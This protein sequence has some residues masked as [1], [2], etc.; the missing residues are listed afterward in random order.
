MGLDLFIIYIGISL[1]AVACVLSIMPDAK[2]KNYIYLLSAAGAAEIGF[3]G[4]RHA[5]G[6]GHAV[7]PNIRISSQYSLSFGLDPI[8]GAFVF[9]I[10]GL[11][12]AASIYSVGYTKDDR[13][14]SLPSFLYG[15]FILSMYAVIA[16]KNV[17]TFLISWETMAVVSYFLVVT[18][19]TE[20]SSR[21]GLVYGVLTHVGT[22][23]I[24]AAFLLI[25][26]STGSMDFGVMKSNIGM[27][28]P[29]VRSLVF[30]FAL[31]G[32]GTKMGAMPMHAWLPR[33]HPAA[34][35][36]V[37][38]LMSGVMIKTG[39]YGLIR[40]AFDIL[41]GG[42][43]WWG[44]LIVAMGAASAILGVLY[45]LTETD[46]KRLLA[47]SSIENM[48]I[49]MLAL[50]ASMMF[51]AAGM[52]AFAGL[53]LLAALYH[54]LNH[55]LF[56]GML[57]MA[58]GSVV[59][60]TGTKNIEKMGGLLKTMPYTGLFFLIGS[61]SICGLPMFNGFV[62]EWMTYQ[63][64]LIGFGLPNTSAKVMLPLSGAALALTGALAAFC[65]VRAFGIGF[66]G[67]ARS[68]DAE[69]A[70]EHSWFM[71]AGM[72]ILA[73]ACLAAGILPGQV[74]GIFSSAVSSLAGSDGPERFMLGVA[75]AETTS[76]VFP[77][78][79]LIAFIAIIMAAFIMTKTLG[80]GRGK[81][82]IGP[83]WD[84]GMRGLTPRMQY[85]GAAFSKPL[86]I[87]FK[88]IYLPRREIKVDYVLKPL[89]AKSVSY[90]ARITPFM[91]KYLYRPL[92]NFI[93]N[94]AMNVRRLQ[95]GNLNVY[96]GYMLITLIVLLLFGT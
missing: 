77:M 81:V 44:M 2:G 14:K 83:S 39:L 22:A 24:I 7:L 36:N 9:I 40:V 18:D 31:I 17:I 43:Q 86:K 3:I 33:A 71:T 61:I 25:Y 26:S 94:A 37:S 29:R 34:P 16:S 59:H 84:C 32:F 13:H 49:I 89:F 54:A 51:K 88:R 90:G 21:A 30:V 4:A 23:F 45:A 60:A 87:I 1:F 48:G 65:F 27:L 66:L 28:S 35:S 85:T 58:A 92:I 46:I 91:E 75:V 38:A 78:A 5:M 82:T 6:L 12:L 67:A 50:G 73:V 55:S 64:L 76:G 47:F 95:S 52:S 74:S 70:R 19:R 62:S 72:G 68:A 53:A 63:S 93:R 80:R 15:L 10:S 20:E 69:F 11:A 41:G 79:L 57:F 8:S 96:L 56:K 42:P